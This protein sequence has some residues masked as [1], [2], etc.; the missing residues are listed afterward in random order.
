[1]SKSPESVEAFLAELNTAAGSDDHYDAALKR[2]GQ[3]LGDLDEIQYRARSVVELMALLLQASVLLRHAP[4]PV[5]EAFT[6]SRLGGGWGHV[7]GTLPRGV[8]TG[9]ILD[10]AAPATET[11]LSMP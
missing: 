5:A 9:L 1:M 10:R 8:D 3:E 7:F 2:L 11:T 4:T 6:A